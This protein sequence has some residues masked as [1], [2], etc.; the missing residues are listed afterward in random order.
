MRARGFPTILSESLLT[1]SD[2]SFTRFSGS[3]PTRSERMGRWLAIAS[4]S[5]WDGTLPG[6]ARAADYVEQALA[7]QSVWRRSL[8]RT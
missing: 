8:V 1:A 5:R 3:G 2:S 7:P 4:E 6:K